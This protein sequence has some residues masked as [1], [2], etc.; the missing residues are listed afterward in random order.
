MLKP[1][2]AD[3][4]I[5]LLNLGPGGGPLHFQLPGETPSVTLDLGAGP[6]PLQATLQTVSI[7]PDDAAL[8]L[9]W[10]A[11]QVYPGHHWLPQMKRLHAEVSS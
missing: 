2:A 5:H 4:H 7:R 11:A 1:V 10:Q 8:D 9:V 6:Q 3:D